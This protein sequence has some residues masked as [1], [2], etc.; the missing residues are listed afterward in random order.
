MTYSDTKDGRPVVETK[1]H[2]VSVSWRMKDIYGAIRN[3]LDQF[4]IS[5][6]L[7][8]EAVTRQCCEQNNTR[9]DGFN[10]LE[11]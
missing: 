11:P 8:N 10:H 9:L 2:I 1:P 3:V 5:C 6:V 7:K 4:G